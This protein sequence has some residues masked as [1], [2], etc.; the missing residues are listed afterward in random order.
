MYTWKWPNNTPFVRGGWAVK[1]HFIP[2]ST[3]WCSRSYRLHIEHVQRALLPK[4]K[5]YPV[6]TGHHESPSFSKRSK[7]EPGSLMT[8]PPKVDYNISEL[9]SQPSGPSL[10]PDCSTALPHLPPQAISMAFQMAKTIGCQSWFGSATRP[11]IFMEFPIREPLGLRKIS[12]VA[13]LPS[14]HAPRLPS[15]PLL[16]D[17]A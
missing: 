10:P 1:S 12:P 17:P 11:G 13:A 9:N 2:L 8:S 16:L 15:L 7:R 4:P 14:Q 5:S 3:K 6:L